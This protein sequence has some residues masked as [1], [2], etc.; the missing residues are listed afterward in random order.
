MRW[1]AFLSVCCVLVLIWVVVKA[2]QRLIPPSNEWASR[3]AEHCED[4]GDSFER[5]ERQIKALAKQY[6]QVK[7]GRSAEICERLADEHDRVADLLGELRKAY[8]KL[9]KALRR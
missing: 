3:M 8:E 1:G 4:L 2:E 6:H 5:M 7:Q 9:E